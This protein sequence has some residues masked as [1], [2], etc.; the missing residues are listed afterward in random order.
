MSLT[1]NVLSGHLES[2]VFDLPKLL[3]KWFSSHV[4]KELKNISVLLNLFA[5][6]PGTTAVVEQG[7]SVLNLICDP[8]TNRLD[9]DHK[10]QLMHIAL[11]SLRASFLSLLHCEAPCSRKV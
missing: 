6:I 5:I 4:K 10:D 9:Q 11:V 2:E 1:S 3:K 8:K 7:W